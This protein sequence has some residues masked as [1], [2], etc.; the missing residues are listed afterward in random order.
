MGSRDNLMGLRT[1]CE[2]DGRSLIPDTGEKF[3]LLHG[4]QT[5]SGAQPVYRMCTGAA[6]PGRKEA[7]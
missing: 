2:L 3:V 7:G 6:S 1:D 5:V 4:F